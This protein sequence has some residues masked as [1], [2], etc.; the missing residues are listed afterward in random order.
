MLRKFLLI[1]LCSYVFTGYAVEQRKDSP[2]LV[3]DTHVELAIDAG[4]LTLTPLNDGALEVY[5][6][7]EGVKQLPSFAIDKASIQSVTFSVDET[8]DGFRISLPEFTVLIQLSPFQLQYE[9]NGEIIAQEEIGLFYQETLRGFRFSLDEHEKI[10]GGGQ[11][12]LGMDRRGNRLPL[13][14]RA[15][16]GYTTESHQMYYSLP[17][18]MS[19]KNYI[20]GFD[21]SAN[22]FLDIGHTE[23]DVLQF[24]AVAGRTAY[25]F[26]AGDDMAETVSYF[27]SATGKQPLPPRWALGNYASRFGYKSQQQTLDVI[28]KFVQQDFPVDAVVLDLYWFG[29]DIKGHMGNLNWDNAHFPDPEAM[30][31]QLQDKGVNL[32]MITEPFI[33]STSSQWESAVKNRALAKNFAGEPRRFDFYFGNSGLVDVFDQNAR[34]WFWQYYDN[35]NRQG[36]AGWWGDLGEPEL[37]PADS[38]H[39]LDGIQVTADEIH[40]VYGHRWA[41]MVYERQLAF[42]P[43]Q[44]P[45]VM[46][47]AGFLGTQRYGMIPWTG[48]VSREWGGL[49]PQVELALQM[50]LFGL[51]YTHSDLGGFAGGEEFDSE[52]YIR[53]LQYGVFQPVYRPHAQDHIPPEPVFHDKNTQDIVREYIKLRYALMPYN[54]SLSIENSLTGLPMMRPLAMHYPAQ[55]I[56]RTDAYLWGEN[57]LVA[58]IVSPGVNQKSVEL[59]QGVWFDYFDGQKLQGGKSV[60]VE[61]PINKLP[62]FVKA[63][64]FIPQ[65]KPQQN[66]QNYSTSS[67][68][69]D[70]YADKSTSKSQYVMYE[71]DGKS[72]DSL[73]TKNYQEILF[74][75]EYS[76]NLV[77]T[78]NVQGHY[79]LAPKT[80]TLQF[81]IFGLDKKPTAISINGESVLLQ[82]TTATWNEQNGVLHINSQLASDLEV[83]INF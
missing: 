31:N 26:S 50:G 77:L 19:D 37:H 18:I 2:I 49:K 79:A 10:M 55:N 75:S 70:F 46:M 42:N 24:E 38:L 80:R 6:Q 29:P 64:S 48:D 14:N 30:I 39:N 47:R 68:M 41:Q 61:S 76:D 78:V 51:A 74:N 40:N 73:N 35:L 82:S 32:I 27:V 43:Q 59:P 21:N 54:Y 58:P 23:K 81:S 17:A 9:K 56:E 65:V 3:S 53:W 7:P 4:K 66:T 11:R 71:D 16:Y 57:F 25:I 28:D 72:P 36:V 5:Y 69:V 62:V 52:L 67:L 1:I 44:R 33:L 22:G 63:G 8:K 60:T 15:H 34:D 20:I 12:V 83:A 13:Y 45:F